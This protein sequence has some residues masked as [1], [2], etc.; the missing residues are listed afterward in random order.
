[1][2]MINNNRQ[3]INLIVRKGIEIHIKAI[4]IIN[5]EILKAILT[6]IRNKKREDMIKDIMKNCIIKEMKNEIKFR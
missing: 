6:K 2:I 3:M 1:M 5:Q 4:T